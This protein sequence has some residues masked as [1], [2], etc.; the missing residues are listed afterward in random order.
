MT[1][2]T[3]SHRYQD[4]LDAIWLAAAEALRLRVTRTDD[5]YATTGGNG[6]LSIAVPYGMDP[7]ELRG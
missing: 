3:I 6:E 1:T 4:P 2:R 7:D 5:A